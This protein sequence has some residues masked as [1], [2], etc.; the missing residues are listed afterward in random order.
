MIK[1]VQGDFFDYD[2]DIRVNTVNCV[3]VM[4]A[5]VALAF[6]EKYPDMF[7]EYVSLCKKE[8]VQPGKPH[9]WESGDLFSKSLTIINLPTK[10]HWRNKSEYEY[11]DKGLEWLREFLKNKEG[12]TLTLPA[13]GCGHGGLDWNIVKNKIMGYLG[14]SPAEI[15]VFE[16]NASKAIKKDTFYNNNLELDL[17]NNNINIMHSTD[18]KYPILLKIFTEKTLFYKGN[19]SNL[20]QKTITLISSTK[21]DDKE[22]KIIEEF[23][24]YIEKLNLSLIIGSSAYDKQMI[25]SINNQSICMFLPSGID[26]FCKKNINREICD[27]ENNLLLSLGNPKIEFDRKEYI[28]SVFARIFLSDITLFTT[29]KLDWIKKHK[30]KFQKYNGAKFFINYKDI[31]NEIKHELYQLSIKEINRDALT[32]KPKFDIVIMHNKTLERN[33]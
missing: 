11:I 16:P 28:T 31:P 33:I 5:G 22:K 32:L 19:I 7:R 6:K 27:N 13:L 17:K 12:K 18:D 24:Y 2:A 4:G 21:P 14:N 26:L 1:F 15:L 30:N 10:K 23:L 9:V 3:G 29:P 20:S 25:K 8:A